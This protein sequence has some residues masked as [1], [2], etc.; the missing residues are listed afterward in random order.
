[1]TLHKRALH[2][3]ARR[4]DTYDALSPVGVKT[5]IITRECETC[6]VNNLLKMYG[7]IIMY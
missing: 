7:I 6:S 1:M 3:T 2:D 5:R 4:Y